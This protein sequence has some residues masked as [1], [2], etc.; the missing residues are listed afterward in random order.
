MDSIPD[1]YFPENGSGTAVDHSQVVDRP[2]L[3]AHTGLQDASG[4]SNLRL[5]DSDSVELRLSAV[6]HLRA[7]L[8]ASLHNDTN[9]CYLNSTALAATWTLLQVQLHGFGYIRIAPALRLLCNPH[10]SAY[11]ALRLIRQLP[12]SLLL[13]GWP[14]LHHQHDV[15]ELITHLFPRLAIQGLATRWEARVMTD[16][17]IRVWDSGTL[18]SPLILPPPAED[19]LYLQRLIDMWHFQASVHALI[20]PPPIIC[21]QLQRF[22][23]ERGNLVRN[24]RPLCDRHHVVHIPVFQQSTTVAVHPAAYKVTAIQLHFGQQPDR[25][26][27]RAI[28]YGQKEFGDQQAWLTDDNQVAASAT[29]EFPEAAYLLW[30]R[31][32]KAD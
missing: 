31:Q 13:Q 14:R 30:L 10:S 5:A 8:R 1:R 4:P 32:V 24:V 21:L 11:H 18:Q 22:S 23:G 27:Y 7:L 9:L 26:H 25:G 6:S 15:P 29:T 28:L 2:I 20:S 3:V 12:W 16:T 19:H 17:G